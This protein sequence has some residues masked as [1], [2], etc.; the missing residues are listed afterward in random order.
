MDETFDVIV[1]GGGV[2]GTGTARDA[3]MRG[4]K[5][6]LVE[7]RD[8][9]AGSSGA[10]T[11]MIHGGL[12]YMLHDRKVTKLSCIDSGYIQKIAPHLLFRIPFL[13]PFRWKQAGGRQSLG[14]RM[15]NYGVEVFFGAYDRYQP[16]KNGRSHTRLSAAEALDL[17]PGLISEIHGA[18]TMDEYGIDP[19]RLCALN[20]R[21][22]ARHGAVVCN[23]T[24]VVGFL[25]GEG[26]EVLGVR[27]RDLHTG[28]V[29]EVRS[30]LV[31][32]ASG[33][34]AGRLAKLA[35]LKVR[36]RPGKGVHLTLDRR[37]SNYAIVS[38][39]ADGRQIFVLP[40]ES[41][42]IVGTTD[43]DYYGDPDDIPITQ[44]EVAYLLQGVARVFPR[45]REARILRAW[46][47]VRNTAYAWGKYEDDLSREHAVIDHGL[48]GAANL[49]TLVGG[50][51]ASYRAQ[52]EDAVNRICARLGRHDRCRTAEVPLP[53]G[54]ST[55]DPSE[56][57]QEF[58][59]PS[60]SV[61][62]AVYRYGSEAA[63]V[64]ALTREE[65]ALAAPVCPCEGTLGAELVYS[66]RHEQA[67]HLVDLRRR[68]RLAMGPCQG[69]RCIAPA[70]ALL[71]RELRLSPDET[72]G[73]MLSLLG[74][75]WKGQRPVATGQGLAQAELT[76]GTYVQ[77]GALPA[78]AP[79]GPARR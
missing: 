19:F 52:A 41:T 74:E 56:L 44:D 5:V 2:N 31:F 43:D 64:L 77:S 78:D 34:W 79:I 25:R 72:R 12:R 37:L 9:A 67:R 4:L 62:R 36:L 10:N 29:E 76:R 54:D 20:A 66:V 13:Y 58:R 35:G 50:K 6:L 45:V 48:E 38:T 3:A 33:P 16:Y 71:A 32:N 65:P 26:G 51:L 57:A 59:A 55:P 14:Q 28:R 69:S 40:H 73:E 18:V 60:Y 30:R 11:G 23:Y 68:C 42:S 8:F 21:D 46:A 75:R 24:E 22:A 63:K 17:E 47:G 61:A 1:I 27:L 53:G 15:Y 7:R 49:F 39:A 70:A